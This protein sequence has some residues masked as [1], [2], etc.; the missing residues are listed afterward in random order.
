M[1]VPIQFFVHYKESVAQI[2]QR[3]P[4]CFVGRTAYQ[5]AKKQKVFIQECW[6]QNQTPGECARKINKKVMEKSQKMKPVNFMSTC[7]KIMYMDLERRS[8]I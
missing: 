4:Y 5:L 6:T 1:G 2:L 8:K 7:T 3:T